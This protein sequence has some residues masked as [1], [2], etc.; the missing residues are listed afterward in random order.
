M[1]RQKGKSQNGGNKKT[2]QAKFSEKRTHL[3]VLG[4]KKF[5]RKFGVLCSLV[6]SDLQFALLPYH[7]R[8]I[9]KINCLGGN[10]ITSLRG[11][12]RG[13]ERV[14]YKNSHNL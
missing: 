14:F 4:G 6:T 11:T 8:T 12:T 3:C 7:R 1:I 13:F 9:M 2:K 10:I 5:S